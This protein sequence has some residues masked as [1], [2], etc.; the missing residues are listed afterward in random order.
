MVNAEGTNEVSIFGLE[1]VIEA[2][3]LISGMENGRL[4]PE[5]NRLKR[6]EECLQTVRLAEWPYT[7]EIESLQERYNALKV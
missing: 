2:E 3:E 1:A 4:L 7:S 5:Y 6:V